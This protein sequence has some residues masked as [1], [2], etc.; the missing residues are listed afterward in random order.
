MSKHA[1]HDL[2][3]LL[4]LAK[5]G[6]DITNNTSEDM[7]I[8]LNVLRFTSCALEMG[9]PSMKK[10]FENA[11]K[12]TRQ[13]LLLLACG[14]N[15]SDCTGIVSDKGGEFPIWAVFD[16][17][18]IVKELICCGTDINC[19]CASGRNVLFHVISLGQ[20]YKRMDG[21]MWYICCGL[22]V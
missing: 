2:D 22:F 21:I 16:P 8:G 10:H 20:N 11:R 13:E 5:E 12:E 6:L 14:C 1:C 7:Q 18:T 17:V 9:D 19:V 15:G 4:A 3:K